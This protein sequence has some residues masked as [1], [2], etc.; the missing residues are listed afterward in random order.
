MPSHHPAARPVSSRGR[1]LSAKS[2][3]A[4]NFFGPASSNTDTPSVSVDANRDFSSSDYDRTQGTVVGLQYFRARYFDANLGRFIG[5]DPLKYVDG[6]SMYSAYFIPNFLDAFGL[7]KCCPKT[8]ALSDALLEQ[9]EKAWE[10]SFKD[11]GSVKEQGGSIIDT[12]N[13]EEVRPGEEGNSGSFPIANFPV[14]GEGETL[15]GTYHTHPYSEEE[16]S[17]EGVGFSGGDIGV[18]VDGNLGDEMYVMSG[19]CVFVMIFCDKEKAGNCDSGNIREAWN[20]AYRNGTGT[21]QERVET[22]VKEALKGCG[23][24]YYQSCRPAKGKPIPGTASIVAHDCP[25]CTEEKG[26]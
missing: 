8:H 25:C 24:C 9:L 14:P 21:F 16:G 26:K 15:G 19:S 1:A 2:G 20:D 22:A 7:E 23:L 10:D 3:Y 17:H 18:F 11:D 12:G 6:M 4:A 5:R 13:G